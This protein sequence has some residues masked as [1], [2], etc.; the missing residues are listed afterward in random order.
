MYF[1]LHQDLGLNLTLGPAHSRGQ[2]LQRDTLCV[3]FLL[4]GLAASAPLPK[5]S[6]N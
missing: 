2:H 1:T 6:L 5:P 3:T 4:T